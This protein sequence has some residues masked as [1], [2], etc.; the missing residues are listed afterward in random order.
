M[1]LNNLIKKYALIAVAHVLN[2]LDEEV[3]SSINQVIIFGSVARG[4]AEK[5]SDV[6]LFFDTN[7]K[8]RNVI[9]K[10]FE[11]FY[12]SREG[13][14]FKTKGVSNQF[15]IIAGRLEEWKELHKSIESEGIVA[16]GQYIS[17]APE[18]LNH[19]FIISWEN[20]DI[21]NRGAFLNKIYGYKIGN[22]KY[23][24]LIKKWGAKK[25]GKSAILLPIKYKQNFLEILSKY[26]IDYRIIDAY[27]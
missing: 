3:F 27:L 21:K 17:S 1:K 5:E 20:L 11:E 26:K 12:T 22:K 24:G 9:R 6:D 13:L 14:I 10:K 19:Y 2:N 16:Y 25:I 15:Q 7:K 4:T 23:K 8:N 18:G